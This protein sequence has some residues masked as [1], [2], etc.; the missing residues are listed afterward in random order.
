METYKKALNLINF[1]EKKFFFVFVIFLFTLNSV[2]EL[3]GLSFILILISFFLGNTELKL[4]ILD[5]GSFINIANYSEYFVFI[6]LV[7]AIFLFFI[8][9]NIFYIFII[10]VKENF[11]N[12]TYINLSN[13]IFNLYQGIKFNKHFDL[14]NSVIIKNIYMETNACIYGFVDNIYTLLLE[15]VLILFLFIALLYYDIYIFAITSI[16]L[17]IVYLLIY[18]FLNGK[19]A[20]LGNER[21]NLSQDLHKSLTEFFALKLFLPRFKLNN[22]IKNNFKKINSNYVYNT[23]SYKILSSLPRLFLEILFLFSLVIVTFTAYLFAYEFDKLLELLSIY[24]I[25]SLRILPALGR[26]KNSLYAISFRKASIENIYDIVN[27]K[28]SVFKNLDNNEFHQFYNFIQLKNLSFKYPSIDK[29]V[30]KKINLT[31]KKNSLTYVCG[32][33]GVGKT[34][35]INTIIGNLEPSEGQIIIDNKVYDNKLS[36]NYG[37][38]PQH[39]HIIDATMRSNITLRDNSDHSLDSQIMNILNLL[40]LGYLISKLRKGLDTNL[41][42]KGLKISGGEKQRIIIARALI[43]KPDIIIF[44]EPTSSLDILNQEYFKKIINKISKKYTIII[45]SHNKDIIDNSWDIIEIKNSELLNI[46]Q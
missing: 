11:L 14:N 28:D 23:L 30:F 10:Y 4:G 36:L 6:T 40:N 38:V 35:L 13:R 21:F 39:I 41:G 7:F 42:E 12:N 25:I 24:V 17:I 37:Y 31:I 1:N 26:S 18:F 46:Q 43:E 5:L 44:D 22:F 33:S 32:E 16:F 34:T 3:L 8:L 29:Y 19:I 20:F 2:L 9:K 15:I 45:I 27:Q